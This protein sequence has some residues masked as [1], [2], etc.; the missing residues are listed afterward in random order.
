[1]DNVIITSGADPGRDVIQAQ[2]LAQLPRDDVV[3]AGSITADAQRADDFAIFVIQRQSA[4]KN[5]YAS[6]LPA[7][8]GIIGLAIILRGPPVSRVSIH[9]IAVLQTEQRST[10][11]DSRVKVRGR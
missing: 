4:A 9:W 6:D 8:H 2:C 7:H 10:R 3:S 5:V 11:L 1:M